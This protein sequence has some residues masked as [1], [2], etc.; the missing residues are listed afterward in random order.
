MHAAETLGAYRANE[1]AVIGAPRANL[2]ATR[3][4]VMFAAGA[5]ATGR[6]EFAPAYVAQPSLFTDCGYWFAS[7]DMGAPALA[8]LGFGCDDNIAAEAALW[9]FVQTF[10]KPDKA[11]RF[12]GSMGGLVTLNSLVSLAAPA[13]VVTAVALLIP[14]LDLDYAYQNNLGGFQ[15]AIG[16][17]Y[18]VA[19][20]TALPALAKHSPVAYSGAD[21]AKLTMPIFIGA[22]DNDPLGANTAACQ[23]WA[24]TVNAATGLGNVSVVSM[25]A[26]GHAANVTPAQ[27]V[28]FFDANGGRQ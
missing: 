23:A 11:C 8:G 16:T 20:P 3:R 14:V 19:W 15:A 21:L 25:G 28:A 9:T 22:S 4:A 26:L 2:G 6:A 12:G 17:A 7:A 27:L 10:A 24:A 5:G 1:I 18:G 13:A